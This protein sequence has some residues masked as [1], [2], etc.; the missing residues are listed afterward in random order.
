MKAAM[1]RLGVWLDARVGPTAALSVIVP[2]PQPCPSC[3]N[4]LQLP[5]YGPSRLS[6]CAGGYPPSVRMGLSVQN[7]PQWLVPSHW[8]AV[9]FNVSEW[10]S[11]LCSK[12]LLPPLS[13]LL[14]HKGVR[15]ASPSLAPRLPPRSSSG[16]S[17]VPSR[18]ATA[19]APWFMVPAGAGDK[20]T[21]LLP[22]RGSVELSPLGSGAAS[23]PVRA[24]PL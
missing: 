1:K 14:G 6:K 8:G 12:A 13:V 7:R 5:S 2:H 23:I 22:G 4:P 3:A 17:I 10:D 9:F 21:S 11:S 19:P 24:V 20:E 16:S 15:S 18:C